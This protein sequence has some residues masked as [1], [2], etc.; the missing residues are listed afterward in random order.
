L[1][2][3]EE[4]NGTLWSTGGVLI[5]A[6]S[7][8]ASGGAQSSG[9]LMGGRSTPDVSCTEEYNKTLSIVDCIL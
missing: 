3:T 2:C 6:R 1:S 4:Y 5:T 7:F 9:L 8:H